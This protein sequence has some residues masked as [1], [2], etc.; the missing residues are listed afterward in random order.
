MARRVTLTPSSR[1]AALTNY[2]VTIL[3]GT[4]DPRVKDVAG[5]ALATTRTWTFRTSLL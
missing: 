5:N 2:T 4:T 3:G 1:L